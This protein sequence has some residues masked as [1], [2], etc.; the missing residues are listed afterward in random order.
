M[1]PS[2]AAKLG[3]LSC[4]LISA[5]L[6]ARDVRRVQHIVVGSG[7]ALS[8]CEGIDG[9]NGN[10]AHVSFPAEPE[11]AFRTRLSGGIGQAP[12][13]DRQGNLFIVHSEPRVSKLD[14]KGRTLWTER[15][16]SEAS[17]TPI[18]TAG[19]ALLIVTREGEALVYSSAGKLQS[20]QMMPLGDPRRRS[21]AIPSVSGGAFLASGSEVFQLDERGAILRML[22]AS[23]ALTT[24]AELDG[25]LIAVSDNG[26]VQVAQATGDLEGVGSFGGRVAEA[27]AV[28]KG[29]VFAVVDGH[30]WCALELN[31][32]KL[33]ILANDPNLTLSGPVA[34]LEPPAAALIASGGFISIRGND[35]AELS[36]SSFTMT[37]QATDTASPLRPGFLIS[38][39]RGTLAAVQSGSDALVLRAQGNVV[40]FEETSCLD[41]FRPTPTISGIVFACR[42]GQLFGISGRAR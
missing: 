34:L 36:R 14:T 6:N 37:G 28:A 29:K 17:S 21:L 18:L 35:G 12:L 42:A 30:K 31:T 15:L 24:I 10:R 1:K 41:P 16:S 27:A 40:R 5:P 7:S 22:H 8:A 3:L 32:G 25:A 38:D 9:S 39:Q 23:S 19:G 20:R 33:A 26:N 4:A 13:S 11:V 2:W